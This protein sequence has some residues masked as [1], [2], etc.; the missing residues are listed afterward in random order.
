MGIEKRKIYNAPLIIKILSPKMTLNRFLK[1]EGIKR[2]L[3][4]SQLRQK[5]VRTVRHRAAMLE[6]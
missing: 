5:S 2:Q 1:G 4:S 3:T 6:K